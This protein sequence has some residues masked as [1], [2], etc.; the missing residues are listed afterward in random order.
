ME[1]CCPHASSMHSPFAS[2]PPPPPPRTLR[3]LLPTGS[4]GPLK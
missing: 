1:P 2:E 3:T 4:C